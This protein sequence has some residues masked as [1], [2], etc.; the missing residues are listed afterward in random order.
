MHT[1]L[2]KIRLLTLTFIGATT[3]TVACSPA[4]S[5]QTPA[6][7]TN[8]TE[9]SN[10]QDMKQ[11]GGMMMQHDMSM[12][13]GP[14][15]AD[16]DLRFIDSMVMHHQ[17]AVNMAQEVLQKSQRPEMKKLAQDIIAAQKQEI[18]QMKQ[19]RTN[20]YPNADQTPMAWH[21]E[22]GHM[23]AMSE[24]MEQ[25]M[26]MSMDLG[27]ADA[28]FD[29][30]FINAMIPHHEGALVMAKDAL[31]KTKRPEMKKLSQAILTSQQQ[32]IDQ[33]KQ[34]RKDWYNQ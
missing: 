12:D 1:I 16:Y 20:W 24:D 25:S 21:P 15:D 27:S 30:R 8:A 5:N 14:A 3:L 10:K 18:A 29:L 2:T 13:I 22:M 31:S 11:D 17:G 28:D 6:S 33:M 19:W 7:N 9:A 34:W 32:E 4:I 26:M 23:M